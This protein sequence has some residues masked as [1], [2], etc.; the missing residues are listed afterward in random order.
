MRAK[1][2]ERVWID[3]PRG[4]LC[5][6]LLYGDCASTGAALVIP[7]HPYMGGRMELPLITAVAAAL[8]SRDIVTLRFDYGGV[9]KSE[10]PP[11]QIG[12]AMQQFWATGAAPED[13]VFID[14]AR[15]ALEWLSRAAACDPALVGY[16]FGA[17]AATRLARSSPPA[18]VMV[19]PTV[20]RHDYSDF[21]NERTP[22]LV[23]YGDGDFATSDEA[24][25]KWSDRLAGHTMLKRIASGD[26]FFRGAEGQVADLCAAFLQSTLTRKEAACP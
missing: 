6:E 11:V 25:K 4:T 7:P 23:I 19:A 3:G 13:P 20:A 8:A 5:G 14:E 24:L 26:H 10:G 12:P 17:Y 18:L 9:G 16:S 2:T 1:N 15:S 21:S 22:T